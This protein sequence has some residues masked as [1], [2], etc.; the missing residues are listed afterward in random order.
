MNYG[1]EG[2]II[3]SAFGRQAPRKWLRLKVR[4]YARGGQIPPWRI[5]I[6]RRVKVSMGSVG[7]FP[8]RLV[9]AVR[10]GNFPVNISSLYSSGFSGHRL[11]RGYHP[12]I[13]WN[14]EFAAYTRSS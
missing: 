5:L 10:E 14:R 9:L 2:G 13:T 7:K 3:L 1:G 12:G 11:S 6:L 8:V 4:A